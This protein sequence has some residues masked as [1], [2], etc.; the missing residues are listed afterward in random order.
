MLLFPLLFTVF[1]SLNACLSEDL[2][3]ESIRAGAFSDAPTTVT[4]LNFGGVRWTEIDIWVAWSGPAT[5]KVNDGYQ[6]C[7][8]TKKVADYLALKDPDRAKLLGDYSA[9]TCLKKP[10]QQTG[11][12]FLSHSSRSHWW[13]AWDHR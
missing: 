12:W 2:N 13:R 3:G 9:L 6:P 11:R 4:V 7:A 5:L 1:L 10:G 8:N